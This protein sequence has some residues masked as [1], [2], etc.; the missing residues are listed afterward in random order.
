MKRSFYRMLCCLTLLLAS[1]ALLAVGAS[2]A[3]PCAIL[4]LRGMPATTRT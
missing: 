2:A 4:I 1:C 3:T